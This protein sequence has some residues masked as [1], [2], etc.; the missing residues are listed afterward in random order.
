M[1]SALS[2]GSGMSSGNFNLA[3]DI[4]QSSMNEKLNAV[5]NEKKR[6]E[7]DKSRLNMQ[8]N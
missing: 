8:L 2:R 5:E 7:R 1:A 6:L 4:L 3:A